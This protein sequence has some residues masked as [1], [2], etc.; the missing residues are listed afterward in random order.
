MKIPPEYLKY[1]HLGS[2]KFWKVARATLSGGG[3][4]GIVV[5]ARTQGMMHARGLLQ[6]SLFVVFLRAK[7]HT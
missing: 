2:Q 3:G 7:G 4:G 6:T 1:P 5:Q